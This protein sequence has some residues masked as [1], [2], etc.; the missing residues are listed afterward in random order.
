[1]PAQQATV[2][3]Y[4][5]AYA[6]LPFTEQASAPEDP[7]QDACP[8]KTQRSTVSRSAVIV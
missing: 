1:M 8:K 2:Q 4:A 5:S 3:S 6:E 7:L